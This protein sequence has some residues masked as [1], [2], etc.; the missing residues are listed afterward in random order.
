MERHNFGKFK[1]VVMLRN[2]LP[3]LYFKQMHVYIYSIFYNIFVINI[4]II[5]YTLSKYC[6]YTVV[7]AK[8]F[9]HGREL[10]FLLKDYFF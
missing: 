6:L 7:V 5:S 9:Y 4:Y 1:I 8:L 10:Y 3:G 2:F